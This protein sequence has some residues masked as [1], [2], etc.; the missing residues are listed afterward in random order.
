MIG[1]SGSTPGQRHQR[2]AA[3]QGAEQAK[4]V[5]QKCYE[6][7]KWQ[8]PETLRSV[9]EFSDITDYFE[10]KDS[11]TGGFSMGWDKTEEIDYRFRPSELIGCVLFWLR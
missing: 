11:R 7:A 3:A 5:L 2:T 6:D 9:A 8:D 4:F 1:A 10:D